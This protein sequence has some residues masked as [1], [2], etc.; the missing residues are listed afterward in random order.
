MAHLDL[1][2]EPAKIVRTAESGCW[3]LWRM[4]LGGLWTLAMGLK[5]RTAP[6]YSERGAW[7]SADI[8]SSPYPHCHYPCLAAEGN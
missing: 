2:T 3:Q 1:S 4:R 7:D 8:I 5:Y 6:A